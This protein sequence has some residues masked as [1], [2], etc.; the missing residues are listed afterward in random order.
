MATLSCG[1]LLIVFRLKTMFSTA[2]S[3]KPSYLTVPHQRATIQPGCMELIGFHRYGSSHTGRYGYQT[4]LIFFLNA[5][6]VL[7]S[8][9]ASSH[10]F[11]PNGLHVLIRRFHSLC[12]VKKLKIRHSLDVMHIERN[13]SANILGHLFG[14]KDTPATRKDMEDVEQSRSSQRWR[15]YWL[16]RGDISNLYVQPRAPYVFTDEEKQ[17]FLNLVGKTQVPTG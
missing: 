8:D 16:T 1:V 4:I 14:E 5:L 17:Q 7:S 15:E 12:D 11:I 13:I 9:H 6:D 2:V 10:S 3:V